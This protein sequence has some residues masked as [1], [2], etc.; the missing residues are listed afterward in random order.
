MSPFKPLHAC[1]RPG[2]KELVR[3]RFCLTHAQEYRR[4]SEAQ[5]ESA[6]ER[7]YD[8]A[9]SKVRVMKLNE[10]PLCERCVIIGVVKG[11]VLVHHRDRN[12]R[13]NLMDNLESLCDP[14]HDKEHQKDVWRR[15]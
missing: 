15:K 8:N 11:A 1:N 4:K 7:G 3:D 2:C 12:P 5:R 9:W 10:A 6:S 14:C 13:N